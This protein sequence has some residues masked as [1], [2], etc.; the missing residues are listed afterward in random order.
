MTENAKLESYKERQGFWMKNVTN[1]HVRIA[2]QL[3][4]ILKGYNELPGWM[5]YG[6]KILCQKNAAKGNTVENYRPLLTFHLCG[7]CLQE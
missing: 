4:K 2:E 7:N 1:L 6:H 3:N 5:T